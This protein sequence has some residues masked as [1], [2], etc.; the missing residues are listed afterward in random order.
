MGINHVMN[1]AELDAVLQLV[2]SLFPQ[3]DNDEYRYSREFWVEKMGELPELLLFARD[4]STVVGSVFG[5]GNNGAVTIGHCGVAEAHRGKGIG[6][7]LMVEVERRATDLGCSR[8]TL[9]ALED[10]EEFYAKLGYSGSLLIQS[11]THSIDELK[12]LNERYEVIG[13]NV[14][15]GTVNQVWL[16]LPATDRELQRKYEETLPGCG[17]QMTFGKPL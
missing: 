2:Y 3:L 8:I 15:E 11:E 16:R 10:A 17:T 1:T 14:Y 5:W 4:G 12:D 13:T 9:G 7:A 6:S